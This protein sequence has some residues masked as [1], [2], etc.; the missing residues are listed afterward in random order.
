MNELGERVMRFFKCCQCGKEFDREAT[1]TH[2][3][4]SEECSDQFQNDFDSELDLPTDE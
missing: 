2:D 1:N 4:C 3:F